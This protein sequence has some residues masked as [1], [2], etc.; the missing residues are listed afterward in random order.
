MLMNKRLTPEQFDKRLNDFFR[1]YHDRGMVKWGGFF[2]SDHKM[3]INQDNKQRQV[4]YHKKSEMSPEEISA[5][6]LKSF[7][8]HRQV[9][10]QLKDLDENG[11]LALD[12]IGFVQGYQ[13]KDTINISGCNVHLSN[14]NHVDIAQ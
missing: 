11:N 9:S 5:L 12:V 6:L 10:I 2:L 4:V 7:S 14:I 1:T 8:E 13:N 3:K